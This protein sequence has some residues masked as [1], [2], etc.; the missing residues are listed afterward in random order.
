MSPRAYERQSARVM[1]L[2][3]SAFYVAILTL[4]AFAF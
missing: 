2:V 1:A 3:M 4:Y